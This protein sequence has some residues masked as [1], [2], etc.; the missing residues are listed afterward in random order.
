MRRE[1]TPAEK[2]LWQH[3]RGDQFM[4]LRFRR[5]Y[6]IGNYIVDFFCPQIGLVIELDGNSHDQQ[7]QYDADRTAQIEKFGERVLRFE[8]TDVFDHIDAV[9]PEIE[10]VAQELQ[11][12]RP[13]PPPSPRVRGE[14]E[15]FAE[16][17]RSREPLLPVPGE[18]ESVD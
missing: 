13:S 14:G 15:Q 7:R 9:L 18:G 4:G 6:R 2:L 8:N 10:R 11:L 3:L 5:Q 17:S 12:A 1:M 16:T